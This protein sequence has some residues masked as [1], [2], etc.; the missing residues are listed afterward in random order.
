MAASI[1]WSE[2]LRR[3]GYATAGGNWRTLQKYA[4]LW[5]I[6]HSHFDPAAATS[7]TLRARAD[8]YQQPLSEVMVEDSRY[9]RASLKRRLLDEGLK[10][11]VCE[12]CGQDEIW[13]GQRMAMILDHING[14]PNDHR[15]ENLRIICPNCAATLATHCGRKNRVTLEMRACRRCGKEFLPRSAET[16]YCSREC[17]CRHDHRTMRGIAQPEKRKVDRPPYEQLIA[18]LEATNFCRVARKYGVSDN[19]V[20]KWVRFYENERRRNEP[21]PPASTMRA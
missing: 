18:E 15:L 5:G 14:V 6:D 12:L 21:E 1:S 10:T 9:P 17:R 7:R 11:R 19:A 3:L 16:R 2:T 4:A 13:C 20:R 8:R